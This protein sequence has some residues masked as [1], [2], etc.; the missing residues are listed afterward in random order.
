MWKPTSEGEEC[1]KRTGTSHIVGG[2]VAKLGDFPWMALFGSIQQFDGKFAY[3]CGGALINKW[4]VLTAA[5]C[6]QRDDG[7]DRSPQ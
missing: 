4:Y 5:H 1:G 7:S 6:I 2:K 3:D